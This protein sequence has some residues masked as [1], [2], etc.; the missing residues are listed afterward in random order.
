M[1]MKTRGFYF[2]NI[3]YSAVGVPFFFNSGQTMS[4]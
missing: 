3:L 4:G 2:K 1:Q